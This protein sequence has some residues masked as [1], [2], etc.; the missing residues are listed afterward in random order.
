VISQV[1]IPILAA[2][3]AASLQA[4]LAPMEHLLVVATAEL[5]SRHRIEC[6]DGFVSVDG[7]RLAEPLRLQADG[8]LD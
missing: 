6:G 4:R 7:R 1:V 8:H 2:D 5:F 3:D